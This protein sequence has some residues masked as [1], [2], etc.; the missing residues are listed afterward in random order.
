ML[1]SAGV[2]DDED[3]TGHHPALVALGRW[4]LAALSRIAV[5]HDSPRMSLGRPQLT[6]VPPHSYGATA[7]T[8]G[9]ADPCEAA[10]N[11]VPPPSDGILG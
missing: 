6:P 9:I 11:G 3:R 5:L 4:L 1:G 7:E 10:A 8:Q 2:L